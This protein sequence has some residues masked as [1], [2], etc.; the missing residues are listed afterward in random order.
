MC[1]RLSGGGLPG[2]LCAVSGVGDLGADDCGGQTF[3]L[4]RMARPA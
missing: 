4:S 3:V 2:H 1:L